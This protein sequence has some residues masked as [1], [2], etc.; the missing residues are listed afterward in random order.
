MKN[1]EN[2][3]EFSS[4]D[5][6]RY[7]K[8]SVAKFVGIVTIR[9]EPRKWHFLEKKK[10]VSYFLGKQ[11]PNRGRR[12]KLTNYPI[13]TCELSIGLGISRGVQ[14][15]IQKHRHLP[16]WVSWETQIVFQKSA[17]SGVRTWILTSLPA[18]LPRIFS[19]TT[20]KKKK[21]RI[22]RCSPDISSGSCFILKTLY[23]G[24]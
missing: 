1:I 24:N 16:I 3:L 8:R 19:Y 6:P 10:C 12:I 4:S 21:N 22:P 11:E 20:E 18:N 13:L 17:T 7:R 9:F 2:G 23:K 14:I 5:I 15:S